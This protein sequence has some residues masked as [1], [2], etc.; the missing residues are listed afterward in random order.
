MLERKKTLKTKSGREFTFRFPTLIEEAEIQ[1][2]VMRRMNGV[3]GM[4]PEY[5]AL[6]DMHYFVVAFERLTEKAPDRY[7]KKF[8]DLGGKDARVVSLEG[9]YEDDEELKEVRELFK[10]F[11]KSFRQRDADDEVLSSG[12]GAD[13][14]EN[15]EGVPP[16]APVSKPAGD[17]GR[18]ATSD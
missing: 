17:L 6:F 8:K 13:E 7:Y 1:T 3:I 4:M 16:P 11:L 2:E 18:G 9:F 10:N 14:V 12:N 15:A 5:N